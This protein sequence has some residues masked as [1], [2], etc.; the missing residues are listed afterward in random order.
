GG[1]GGSLGFIGGKRPGQPIN[2][3]GQYPGYNYLDNLFPNVAG[4]RGVVNEPNWP[5]N[6]RR[7]INRVNRRDLIAR[8]EQGFRITI[9]SEYKDH[10]DRLASRARA[11]CLLSK[12]AWSTIS[13]HSPGNDYAIDW[14]NINE[15]GVITA[16]WLMGRVRAPQKGDELGWPEP[17]SWYFEDS[18]RNYYSYIAKLKTVSPNRVALVLSLPNSQEETL[19]LIIDTE[20]DV[21]L[22]LQSLS[23]G[24]V[25]GVTTYS[26]FIEV[27]TAWWPQQITSKNAEGKIVS[28]SRITVTALAKAA[29]AEMMA[30]MLAIKKDAILLGEEPA[31]IEEAKQAVKD[32]KARFADHWALLR[33][34]AASQQWD[35]AEPHLRTIGEIATGKHGVELIRLAVWQ[36]SRRNE[37]IKNLLKKAV[38]QLVKTPCEAEY[39]IANQLLNFSAALN[40][41]NERLELLTTLKPVYQR[42]TSLLEPLQVWDQFVVQALQNMGREEE[43]FAKQREMAESYPFNVGV[44][45]NYASM[46]ASRGEVDQAVK[47]LAIAVE[48][49]GPWLE[50]ELGQ[51]K[52]TTSNILQSNYRFEEFVVFLQAWQQQQPQT[53]NQYILS[54]YLSTL[55]MLDREQE[56]NKLIEEWLL[57][58]RKEKLSQV[59]N[60]R[61]GA[62]IQQALGQGYNR[63]T[64]RI[65]VRFLRLLADTARYF[66]DRETTDSFAGQILQNH[67]FIRTDIG[68]ALQLELYR[69]LQLEC[70]KLPVEKVERLV[71]WLK[72]YGFN[73]DEGEQGWQKILDE[74]YLRWENESNINAKQVLANII[75]SYGRN[76]LKLKYHR[77]IFATAT[78]PLDRLAAT[79]TLFNVLL[80]EKWSQPVEDELL[81]L[82]PQLEPSGGEDQASVEKYL[83][84]LIIAFYRLAEWLP[85]SRSEAAIAALPNVNEMSRRE[86]KAA[87]EQALREARS[88]YLRLFAKLEKEFKPAALRPWIAIERI[89]LAVK[90]RVDLDKI[91]A[92]T[93][94]LLAPVIGD[95][96]NKKADNILV[97]DHILAVRCIATLMYLAALEQGRKEAVDALLT[98]IDKAIADNHE[99]VDW[100]LT[101]Y[102]LLVALDRGDEVAAVLKQW[103]GDQGEFSKIRWGRG[104]AYILAERNQLKEAVKVFEEIEKLDELFYQDYRMLAD[105]YIVL[106]QRNQE[107]ETR[108]K[109]WQAV[110]ENIIY[111]NLSNEMNKYQRRGED[112]PSELDAEVPIKLVALLR[113]AQYP[114]NYIWLVTS[115]YQNVKDFRLLECVPEAVIGQSAQKIYPFLQQFSSITNLVQEEATVD[116]LEKHLLQIHAKAHTDVDKR[117]LKLLEFMVE[118]RATDQANGSGPHAAAALR[119]LKEAYRGEYAEGEPE[120]MAQFLASQGALTPASLAN[121]QLR[122]LS[123]LYLKARPGS[124]TRFAIAGHLASTQWASNKREAAIRTL[125]SALTEY[126]QTNGGL[127]PQ[128]A[129][130][131]LS[132]YCQYLQNVGNFAGAEKV[133]LDELKQPHNAQQIYWLKQQLYQ[134]YYSVL[135]ADAVVSLGSREELYRSVHKAILKELRVRTNEYYSGD[136][137]RIL[138]DIWYLGDKTLHYSIVKEDI[139]NFAFQ[140]LPAILETYNY[141]N[142]QNSVANV[143]TRLHDIAG[144]LTALEFLIVR[145]EQEPHWLRVQN[146]DF[147]NQQGGYLIA[148]YRTESRAQASQLESRLLKL[149]LKELRQDLAT[150]S[151]RNRNIYYINNSYF[152]AEKRNEFASTAHAVLAEN[153][154]SEQTL[155]YVANYF[156][157]GLHLYQEAIDALSAAHRKE[158]LGVEGRYLLC[159]YLHQQK[160]YNESLPILIKLVA[161]APERLEFRTMLLVGY[162]HTGRKESL[163]KA[164]AETDKYFHE[165]GL[166]QEYVIATLADAC[167]EAQLYRECAAY[168]QESIALHVKSSPRRGIGDGTLSEY[169]HNMAAAYS[170]L[171]MT[172]EAVD[173]AAG[174]I[175]SWGSNQNNRQTELDQLESV[176]AKAQDLDRY[177]TQLDTEVNRSGLDNPIVRKALGKV[178]FNKAQ[179][180]KAETQLNLAIAGQ[181]NDTETY[182]L[183]IQVYDRQNR[184]QQATAQLLQLA[185]L[186]GHQIEIYQEVGKRLTNLQEN[187]EAERAFTNIVEIQPNESESHQALAQIRQN[188]NRWEEA[189]QQWREVIRVRTK[190]PTGYLGLAQALVRLERWSE[191]RKVTTSLLEQDWPV[192]FGDVKSQARTLAEQIKGQALTGEND[193]R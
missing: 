53:V 135:A 14:Y 74:I 117:A 89:Y 26:D 172:A 46:L 94:A 83:D 20:K 91:T 116:R 33:Y 21:V 73:N 59:D 167:L 134:H 65:E 66:I 130:S 132:T 69:R 41:G 179:L 15:R 131:M 23:N 61:L 119:A 192:H 10:R 30:K 54:Q 174:A 159:Q 111:R 120:L 98:I 92:E 99:L 85:K 49:N 163:A 148:Q 187:E 88:E 143:A 144:P 96:I 142:G 28:I 129:N 42:Q 80:M 76:E 64:D 152:W 162:F 11:E 86:L 81:R 123:E 155:I 150:L 4:P 182:R 109:S 160:H 184:P 7:V 115:Y 173:A 17:F 67:N 183:L 38:T 18:L 68:R 121:E 56:A 58:S 185:K 141:R 191:A 1:A 106:N 112:V 32:G 34:F 55:I 87:N 78:T 57:A 97:R 158:L 63:Y 84:S 186:A 164:L 70:N 124:Y 128:G 93:V 44:Q 5:D 181:P 9:E 82:L 77:K 43:A 25:T 147:W 24:S 40:Q 136:L 8:S 31:K 180:K 104:Y 3:R 157:H 171:G 48:K 37:E 151:G 126:R 36:A 137:I 165:N 108:V 101:K 161:T 188:Q 39:G 139:V 13:S 114:A 19:Q 169:Y 175:I 122:Q 100:R 107:R 60:Y 90:L 110:D 156:Y 140:N 2:G 75:L 50:Y 27:G 16:A 62:A 118:R 178:Y 145:A 133:W 170:G 103:Y 177:V 71:S 95:T 154:S 190:E 105:L 166:W 79:H 102:H 146:Q 127:L 51:L 176:L 138:C 29:F 189:A 22:E 193:E 72:P 153:I 35:K 113:K 12:D 52:S 125:T 45:I 149:V 47:H 168:Y 6:I